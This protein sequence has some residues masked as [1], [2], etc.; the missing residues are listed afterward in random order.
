MTARILLQFLLQMRSVTVNRW[1]EIISFDSINE[2][3]LP[4]AVI[5]GWKIDTGKKSTGFFIRLEVLTKGHAYIGKHSVANDH[6]ISQV[7]LISGFIA[8]QFWT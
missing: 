6:V 3:P 8:L 7:A 1:R 5:R 2:T 4:K